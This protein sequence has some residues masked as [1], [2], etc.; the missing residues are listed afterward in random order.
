MKHLEAAQLPIIGWREAIH[1][2]HHAIYR[3][4]EKDA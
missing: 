1:G 2:F 3:A 4:W